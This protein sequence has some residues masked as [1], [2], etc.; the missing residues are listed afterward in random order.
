METTEMISL[1]QFCFHHSVE[2]SFVLALQESGLVTITET[3]EEVCIPVHELPMLEKFVRMNTEMEINLA[4]IEAIAHLLNKID[5][6][7][8]EITHLTNRLNGL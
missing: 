5:T 6:M 3:Q 1:Q 7:Q 4:G 2:Q 8:Q